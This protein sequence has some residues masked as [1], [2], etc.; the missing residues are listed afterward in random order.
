M[1]LPAKVAG[2][3]I[4][5]ET[6]K[7]RRQ[8]DCPQPVSITRFRE[9]VYTQEPANS[10]KCGHEVRLQ[11]KHN[12]VGRFSFS[13]SLIVSCWVKSVQTT[14]DHL[15]CATDSSCCFSICASSSPLRHVAITFRW[16]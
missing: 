1:T 8:L 5:K 3:Q 13:A 7:V 2:R 14:R 11:P 6:C 16:H 10:D 12:C 4:A 9:S 15:A